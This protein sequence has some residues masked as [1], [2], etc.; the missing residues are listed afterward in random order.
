MAEQLLKNTCF[1]EINVAGIP[2]NTNITRIVSLINDN[3]TMHTRQ[4]GVGKA[5]SVDNFEPKI[6]DG[7]RL[8]LITSYNENVGATIPPK[9]KTDETKNI[10]L[11][12]ASADGDVKQPPKDKTDETKNIKLEKASADGDVKQP[13]FDKEAELN[14]AI[15]K[16]LFDKPA[17]ITPEIEIDFKQILGK[18][19]LLEALNSNK[20]MEDIK[21]LIADAQAAAKATDGTD[22]DPAIGGKRTRRRKTHGSKRRNA[23][24]KSGR[25]ASKQSRRR[26]KKQSKRHGRK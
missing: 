13:P 19:K 1:H 7:A 14:E 18:D 3:A 23:S 26:G 9:D 5:T 4:A 12:K 24:N 8:F 11:E 16:A 25:R 15:M 10:K 2:N 17:R 21:A 6:L 20:N 22:V